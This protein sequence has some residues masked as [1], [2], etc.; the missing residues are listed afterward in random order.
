SAI[1]FYSRPLGDAHL[2]P[3]IALAHE[4]EPDP[5]RL[6][7]L[8]IGERQIGQVD[9]RFLGD[10]AAFLLRALLL[11]ALD[12]VDAAHQGAA[13]VGAY[14]DPLAGAP[15]VAAGE[16]DH[17]VALADFRRHHSTSGASEMIF[18]WFLARSSRGTGPNMRVPTGSICGLI[19]TAALRSKRMIEP[20]GRLMSLEMRTTTAFITSPF[21]TRPRGMASFTDTT[22]TSPIVPYLPF[23]PPSTLMPMTR[24]APELSATSRFVCIWIMTPP[25][26]YEFPR[27][28]RSHGLLLLA[29]NHLPAFELGQWPALFD[30]H[31][32]VDV[33]L[34]RLVVGMVFLGTPHRLLH[35]RM[36]EAA[37]DSH[38]N[39][40]VL[41]VAHYDALER[42]FRH[43]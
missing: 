27:P 34:V 25:S 20:S 15:L 43:L 26:S 23:D 32:V 38:H 1:D 9:G 3:G 28:L 41:F 14:L 42:A 16:H 6:A 39:G 7:V 12:H 40:L 21:F 13:L 36:G 30:P 10:D 29:P 24:R 37:L 5:G 18:M 4:L 35:D 31:D 8:G 2:A 19:S 33:V 11:V 22:I 17:L